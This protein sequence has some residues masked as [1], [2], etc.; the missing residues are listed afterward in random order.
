MNTF[1]D[2]VEDAFT[3]MREEMIRLFGDH[4]SIH[5]AVQDAKGKVLT[6]ASE[7]FPEPVPAEENMPPD[8]TPGLENPPV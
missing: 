7:H 2:K 3:E 1:L 8:A 4:T 5:D 6:A